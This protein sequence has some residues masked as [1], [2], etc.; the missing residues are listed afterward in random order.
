MLFLSPPILR[1]DNCSFSLGQDDKYYFVFSL[2]KQQ[3]NDLPNRLSRQ[4]FSIAHKVEQM[5]ASRVAKKTLKSNQP[6]WTLQ[7]NVKFNSMVRAFQLFQFQ[8]DFRGSIIFQNP[9]IYIITN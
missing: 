2:P 8:F 7:G 1:D 5:I 4:A 9:F 6:Q 3:L